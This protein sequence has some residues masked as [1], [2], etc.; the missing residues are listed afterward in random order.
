MEPMFL[1]KPFAY[2]AEIDTSIKKYVIDEK[3]FTNIV[4]END[5]LRIENNKLKERLRI[6]KDITENGCYPEL[7]KLLQEVE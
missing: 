6:I 4:L 1:G 3:L 5:S 2:W 7:D